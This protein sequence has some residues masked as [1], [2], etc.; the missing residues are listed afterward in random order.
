VFS[1]GKIYAISSTIHF[2]GAY[3]VFGYN[4]TLKCV[5]SNTISVFV[6]YEK[7]LTILSDDKYANNSCLYGLYINGND[8]CNIG[9]FVRNGKA[10]K[11]R[12][13]Y[14]KN[15]LS[16]VCRLGDA[17]NNL[18]EVDVQNCTFNANNGTGTSTQGMAQYALYIASKTA[19]GASGETGFVT[20]SYFSNILLIN[21]STNWAYIKASVCFFRDIHAY[22]Y[23][24]TVEA[25]QCD[26]GFDIID[27]SNS[28]TFDNIY[29]DTVRR[30]GMRL[31]CDNA[32]INNVHISFANTNLETIYGIFV[33]G[34]NCSI[35]NIKVFNT[36]AIAI[37]ID[38][39]NNTIDKLTIGRVSGTFTTDVGC[40][41]SLPYF[42]NYD[43]RITGTGTFINNNFIFYNKVPVEGVVQCSFKT[44]RSNPYY[45][46]H[47]EDTTIGNST[48]NITL[49]THEK[50]G[51]S[52][53]VDSS[54]N[55]RSLVVTVSDY[56]GGN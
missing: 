4:S 41:G 18:W 47:V 33:K 44:K 3:S 51:F 14:I 17:T 50:T 20:D 52:F 6:S 11:L 5:A 27:H 39:L 1:S 31:D 26:V 9:L 10:I 29:L 34:N 25:E 49:L 19:T 38:T 35:D 54:E 42:F 46:I 56:F 45:F 2:N 15:C 16:T 32:I 22:S 28:L 12:D 23:P 21:G 8:K 7:P 48:P 30:I 43:G 13:L 37:L 24:A 55:T 40:N 53:S 36:K